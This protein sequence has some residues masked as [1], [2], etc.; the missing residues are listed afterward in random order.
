MS[1]VIR[2]TISKTTVRYYCKHFRI[3]KMKF[4]G[5]LTISRTVR[6]RNSCNCHPW[7][8]GA[9][10]RTVTLE[11]NLAVSYKVKHMTQQSHYS[12][13]THEK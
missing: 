13:F 9:Q 12:E 7:L 4:K 3:I 11:N 10:N 5:K 6:M 8:V 1:L 2:K